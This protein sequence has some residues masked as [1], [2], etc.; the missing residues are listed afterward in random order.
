M[1]E[2]DDETVSAVKQ[3]A[4]LE[5]VDQ[6]AKP[7]AAEAAPGPQS[8]RLFI[9]Y[10]S[11]DAQIAEA[12]AAALKQALGTGYADVHLD[13]WFLHAGDDFKR[14]IERKLDQTDYLVVVFTGQTKQAHGYTGWEL[15]YFTSVM[16]RRPEARIVP[17]YLTSPPDTARDV[18]G[19]SIGFRD[20]LLELLPSTFKKR[21][22]VNKREPICHFFA[23]LQRRIKALAAQAN[24]P[25]PTMKS[26]RG[27]VQ[28]MRTAIFVALRT[29]PK[30]VIR[31]Q[32][33]IVF[34]MTDAAFKS[35]RPDLPS[36]TELR[37][38]GDGNPMQ[39]FGLPNDNMTWREFQNSIEA[40]AQAGS[41]QRA[42]TTVID[43]SFPENV[44]VD[45][46]QII[47][48]DD[49]K[50]YR[51]ILTA[52]TSY[53]D[54]REF[55][56][57]F[58]D[59]LKPRELGNEASSRLLKGL[60]IVCRFRFMFLEA[61]SDFSA[62]AIRM[63]PLRELP[64]RVRDL[65]H[66]LDML[67]HDAMQANFDQPKDW[68][69]FIDWNR[70]VALNRAFGVQD[71]ALRSIATRIL[72]TR[73]T[74]AQGKLQKSLAKVI[75]KIEAIT[76]SENAHFIREMAGQLQAQADI[77]PASAARRSARRQARRVRHAQPVR[78]GQ[79]RR[80]TSKRRT[81]AAQPKAARHAPAAKRRPR[82]SK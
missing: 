15:G 26:P 5:D 18:Q 7:V 25:V 79:A 12:V 21:N 50:S 38:T 36:D 39:I 27:C 40:K 48:A 53:F 9:S 44:N 55:S 16:K 13:R 34:Q 31:P 43:S 32:K 71:Q 82:R 3:A 60:A 1:N 29:R 63:T 2:N 59:T 6:Q 19:F 30:K 20:E 24:R 47:V 62:A 45:N 51:I 42:I 67:R 49:G 22:K 65:L 33:Q 74:R 10:A 14:E 57:S 35:H 75:S 52:G 73:G 17:M 77:V 78:A 80:L 76:R 8:L 69:A 58:V 28:D 46:S 81:G 23:D 37:P 61:T 4:T 66:E 11:E 64:Q 41:W 70:L 54:R 56:L 68:E 72:S